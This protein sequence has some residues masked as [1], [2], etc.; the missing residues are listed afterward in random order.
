[1]Q[2]FPI[3][4]IAIRACKSGGIDTKIHG[5]TIIGRVDM[6]EDEV[7]ASFSFLTVEEESG[8]E[9]GVLRQQQKKAE[10][11]VDGSAYKVYV[12]GLNDRS[13]LGSGIA[14]TKVC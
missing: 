10:L 9:A 1:M 5:I 8:R 6:N 2:Y 12:W 4:E 14:D 11:P 7:A 13:Q 3:I